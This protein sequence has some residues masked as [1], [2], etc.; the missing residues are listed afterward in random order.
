[1]KKNVAKGLGLTAVALM[2]IISPSVFAVDAG[3]L[4]TNIGGNISG[5]KS[6]IVDFA[7]L[8]GVILFVSG[9]FLVYKDSKQPGQ[10]HAKKGMIA[11]LVGSALLVLPFMVNVGTSTISDEEQSFITSGSGG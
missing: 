9:L 10:D 1:M 8:A 4:A 5:I 11:I 3:T 6:L 2:G 7:F